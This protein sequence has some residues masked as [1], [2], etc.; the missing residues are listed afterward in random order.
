MKALVRIAIPALVL[1]IVFVRIKNQ[2]LYYSLFLL[3]FALA[4]AYLIM[5]DYLSK[6]MLEKATGE[7][8]LY[9]FSAGFLESETTQN[10]VKGRVAVTRTEVRF[11]ARAGASGGCRL[12]WSTASGEISGYSFDKVD[13]FHPGIILNLG[14]DRRIRFTSRSIAKDEASFRTALGW[15]AEKA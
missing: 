15:E 5:E 8:G 11:Y 13:S 12:L 9:S 4:G 10:I 1:V 3:L 2:V 14:E 6:G 7:K